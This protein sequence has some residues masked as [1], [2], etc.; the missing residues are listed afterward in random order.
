MT[1]RSSGPE[2]PGPA[3]GEKEPVPLAE[4]ALHPNRWVSYVVIEGQLYKFPGG[5]VTS[6]QVQDQL[7]CNRINRFPPS[8]RGTYCIVFWGVSIGDVTGA[9]RSPDGGW[10]VERRVRLMGTLLGFPFGPPVERV[11][12]RA[13]EWRFAPRR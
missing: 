8:G 9:R 6:V 5:R 1:E 12:L 10:W 7:I 2:Q 3:T 4:L 11:G 13:T